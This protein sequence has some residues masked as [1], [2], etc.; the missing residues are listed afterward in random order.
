LLQSRLR[1]APGL[2]YL[3]N[4]NADAANISGKFIGIIDYAQQADD[5]AHGGEWEYLAYLIS[6]CLKAQGL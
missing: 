4:I 2:E 5:T 3:S 6:L 1:K